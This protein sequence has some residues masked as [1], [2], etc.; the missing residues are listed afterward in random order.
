[1]T[2]SLLRLQERLTAINSKQRPNTIKLRR[3]NLQHNKAETE[4]TEGRADVGAFKGALGSADFD[5]S[6]WIAV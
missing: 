3:K 2:T 5:E 6:A 1:M 4:L